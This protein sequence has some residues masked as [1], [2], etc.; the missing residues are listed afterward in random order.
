MLRI[1]FSKR[2]NNFFSDKQVVTH[3]SHI[4]QY[5][6][7]SLFLPSKYKYI[8]VDENEPAD[9][10][11]IGIQHEDNNLLCDNEMNVLVTVENLSVGRSHYGHF[12]RFLKY[13]ND[14]ID[15][16]YYNDVIELTNNT[17]PISYCFINQ[18][19]CIEKVYKPILQHTFDNKLFC[20]AIS[21]NNLNPNK[22][23][24]INEMNKI[25]KV[26]YIS[27]YDSL[28]LNKSCYNTPELL[29][30]FNRYKFIICFENSHT[31]GYITEKIFN[32]FLAKSVPIYDG[33]PDIETYIN[34]QAFIKYDKYYLTKIFYLL[35][36]KEYYE[37]MVNASK[38]NE[39]NVDIQNF[40]K[41]MEKIFDSHLERKNIVPK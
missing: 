5:Q 32:V 9:I 3:Y 18:Y 35:T 31:N 28:L 27:Q 15:L 24:I 12:N 29:T 33:A 16:Y 38:F 1:R 20:L 22:S 8:V 25:G 2:D 36:N 11:I 40:E 26:D 13:G 17:I 19:K 37:Y 41:N 7:I 10:C 6:G 30:V 14:K 34:E 4:E 23:K 21:K 39:N